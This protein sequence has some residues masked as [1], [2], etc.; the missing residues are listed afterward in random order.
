MPGLLA[1]PGAHTGNPERNIR[2]TFRNEGAY[3]N[4]HRTH[5]SI[6]PGFVV[7]AVATALLWL[8]LWL[9]VTLWAFR[10]RSRRGWTQL[11][12]IAG[13]LFVDLLCLMAPRAGPFARLDWNWQ[14]KLLGIA[15]V[16]LLAGL[17]GYS[18]SRFGFRWRLEAGALAPIAAAAV[19]AVAFGLQPWLAGMQMSETGH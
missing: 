7:Q 9:P 1:K 16:L 14:G 13:L 18:L 10:S 3:L 19:A 17:P 2:R 5:M 12:L 4:A 6:L 11:V 8:A 15:W